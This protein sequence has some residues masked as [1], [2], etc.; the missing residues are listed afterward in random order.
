M[1]PWLNSNV[2]ERDTVDIILSHSV[3]EH[4]VDL[5]TTY[6]ALYLWLK[7]KGMMT[8]QIDFASHGLSEQWNGYRAYSEL[9]WKIIYGKRTY[10][11]NRQPHS[12]HIDQILKNNFDVICDLQNYRTDGIQRSTLSEYWKN[13]TDDDLSCSEA[14]IQAQK[15]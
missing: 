7:P 2:I 5:E 3:L 11:I 1:V 12:V 6:R 14:F 13:I 4:V 15:Q 8:H 9:L 10:L